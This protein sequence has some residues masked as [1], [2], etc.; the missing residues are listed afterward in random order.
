M[1]SQVTAQ[2]QQTTTDI[3]ASYIQC[4][5]DNRGVLEELLALTSTDDRLCIDKLPLRVQVAFMGLIEEFLLL[6]RPT[7]L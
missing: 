4:F 5:L 1:G 6:M 3:L 7:P 2:K